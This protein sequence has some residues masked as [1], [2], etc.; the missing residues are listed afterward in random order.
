MALEILS[1]IQFPETLELNLEDVAV[2]MVIAKGRESFLS[3]EVGS[4]LVPPDGGLNTRRVFVLSVAPSNPR[5]WS[6]WVWIGQRD[7]QV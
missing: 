5:V 4:C 2:N 1:L 3:L 6:L 7:G